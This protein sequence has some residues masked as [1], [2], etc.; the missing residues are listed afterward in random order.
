MQYS[1][2]LS[3]YREDDYTV[4]EKFLCTIRPP[5]AQRL[6]ADSIGTLSEESHLAPK[7]TQGVALYGSN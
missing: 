5:V 6:T 1:L 2:S 4:S 7:S 3:N